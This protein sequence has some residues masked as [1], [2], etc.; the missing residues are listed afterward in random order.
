MMPSHLQHL[1]W[2]ASRVTTAGFASR[3]IQLSYGG[4]REQA[5]EWLGRALSCEGYEKSLWR[6]NVLITLADLYSKSEPKTAANYS[7]CC[8]LGEGWGSNQFLLRRSL[9]M[10][11]L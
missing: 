6:R 10:S 5:I 8:R 1:R 2:S 3:R 4:R 11:S 9:N 7:V